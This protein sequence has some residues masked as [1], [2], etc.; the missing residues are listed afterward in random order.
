ML[1]QQEKA[2][3]IWEWYEIWV[4][5][6]AMG[7]PEVL[8]VWKVVCG[9]Q[10]HI[11]ILGK[12]QGRNLF[13]EWLWFVFLFVFAAAVFSPKKLWILS[14]QNRSYY[15]KTFFV[16]KKQTNKQTKK[17]KNKKK[18]KKPKNPENWS[19]YFIYYYYTPRNFF[20]DWKSE[21]SFSAGSFHAATGACGCFLFVRSGPTSQILTHTHTHTPNKQ[22]Q[23]K[24]SERSE[25]LIPA[26][27]QKTHTHTHKKKHLQLW[28]CE[29]TVT[30][31]V[32]A[33]SRR[34]C[35]LYIVLTN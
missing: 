7:G 9:N 3:Q 20:C 15:D 23:N 30:V 17:N 8:S 6:Q 24:T 33:D 4:R 27:R 14:V 11:F 25:S 2:G 19:C 13:G 10:N 16:F 35:H 28:M 12:F 5:F 1:L 34:C 21:V 18:Q 29:K 22:K 31:Y 32:P 26:T